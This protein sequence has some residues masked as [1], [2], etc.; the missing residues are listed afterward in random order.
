M[1]NSPI[2]LGPSLDKRII[3]RIS[4]F[5]KHIPR[6]RTDHNRQRGI[7]GPLTFLVMTIEVVSNV[8]FID[9]PIHVTQVYWFS[10]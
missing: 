10:F 2:P 7:I 8:T 9:T 4:L 3:L 6:P 5:T 1:I